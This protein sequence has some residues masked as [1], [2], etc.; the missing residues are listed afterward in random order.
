MDFKKS[1]LVLGDQNTG[2]SGP[3][4]YELTGAEGQPQ[5]IR[6]DNSYLEKGSAKALEMESHKIVKVVLRFKSTCRKAIAPSADHL[7]IHAYSCIEP[8]FSCVNQ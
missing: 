4:P 7:Q 1:N 3:C 6:L 5:G 2:V 8:Q